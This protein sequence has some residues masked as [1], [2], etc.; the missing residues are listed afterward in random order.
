MRLRARAIE[1]GECPAA[2][3]STLPKSQLFLTVGREY[4]AH[5]ISVT[6]GIVYVHVV[7]DSGLPSWRPVWFFDLVDGSIPSDWICSIGHGDVELILGPEFVAR[8]D[9]ALSAMAAL[10]TDQVERF[11]ARLRTRRDAD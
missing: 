7:N 11:W 10:E 2:I 3:A 8:D 4:E 6:K 1:W 5:A 9:D